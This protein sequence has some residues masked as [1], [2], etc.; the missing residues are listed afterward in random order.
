MKAGGG[1]VEISKRGQGFNK[2]TRICLIWYNP[3][4]QV[5]VNVLPYNTKMPRQLNF[6]K[7]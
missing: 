1:G 6:A 7:L 5:S 4:V 3:G 2:Q